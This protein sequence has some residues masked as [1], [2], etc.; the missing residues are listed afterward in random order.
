MHL[1]SDM[2]YANGHVESSHMVSPFHALAQALVLSYCKMKNVFMS[3]RKYLLKVNKISMSCIV[4]YSYKK[5]LMFS[6]LHIA[7]GV[8]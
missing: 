8:A 7:I 1:M 6:H 3:Y 5:L 2:R 4:Q